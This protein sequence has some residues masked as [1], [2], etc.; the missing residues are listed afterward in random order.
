MADEVLDEQTEDIDELD[1]RLGNPDVPPDERQALLDE[2]LRCE[3]EADSK[4]G[5]D[6]S[7]LAHYGT[8]Y[9]VERHDQHIEDRLNAIA[10]AGELVTVEELAKLDSAFRGDDVDAAAAAGTRLTELWAEADK[11]PDPAFDRWLRVH[12]EEIDDANFRDHSNMSAKTAE[13]VKA[14]MDR[15]SDLDR[16]YSERMQALEKWAQG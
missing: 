13:L 8:G 1:S 7:D 16:A 15:A 10:K 11:Q 2:H 4:P 3:E 5:E 14:M 12:K 6:S 9:A